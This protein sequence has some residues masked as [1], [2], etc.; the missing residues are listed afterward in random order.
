MPK[1]KCKKCTDPA[2]KDGLCDKH[3]RLKQ[4]DDQKQ[5]AM[6]KQMEKQAA[7]A[8][9]KEAARIALVKK[10]ED[11]K[12]AK[13]KKIKEIAATWNTQVKAIAT[14]VINLRKANPKRTGI[15]A[16]TNPGLATIPGGTGNPLKFTVPSNPH[17]ITTGDVF[18][19]MT[20]F[21]GSDSSGVKF[22]IDGVFVHCA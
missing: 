8:K 22:R 11:T 2:T 13:E 14:Q 5:A 21:E 20:G 1:E 7:E 16:G 19:G 3:F 12:M 6:K 10:N 9:E 15:N 18:P 17:G 4:Q